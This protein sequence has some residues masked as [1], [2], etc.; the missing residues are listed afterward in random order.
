MAVLSLHHHMERAHGLVLPQTQGVDVFGGELETY[1]VSFPWALKL[2][3]FPVDSF[4]ER[5]NN[6]GRIR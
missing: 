3:V 2:V 5:E 6:P 4:P 1:V